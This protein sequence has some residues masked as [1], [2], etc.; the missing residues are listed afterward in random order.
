MQPETSWQLTGS[1]MTSSL[2]QDRRDSE[3]T[4][5]RYKAEVK[6][7]YWCGGDKLPFK[8]G[9]AAWSDL[10]DDDRPTLKHSFNSLIRCSRL[11]VRRRCAASVW[12]SSCPRWRVWSRR[13]PRASRSWWACRRS[14]SG[15][16]GTCSKWPVWGRRKMFDQCRLLIRTHQFFSRVAVLANTDSE[17]LI[18]P[19]DIYFDFRF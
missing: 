12:W 3:M 13:W 17:Y 19:L 6:E 9:P 1:W 7:L 10:Q 15:S 5:W 4:V 11:A 2:M 8:T 16:C 14:V 18:T